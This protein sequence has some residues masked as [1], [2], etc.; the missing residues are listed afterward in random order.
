M[1][2]R[3]RQFE[4]I[5]KRRGGFS[6]V[7]MIAATA[8]VAGTLAPAL[9]VMRDAMAASREASR[10]NLLAI[11]AVQTLEYAAGATMQSWTTGT[12]AGNLAFEGYPTIRYVVTRSDAP[13][14]GGIAGQLMHVQVTV[15][16]DE[17]GNSTWNAGEE[18]VRFRTKVAKLLTYENEAN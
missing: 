2:R 4:A 9:T 7:E 12:D 5:A 6:L 3:R 1:G 10:R 8:L 17:N 11:Y 16:D 15:F 18:A 14:N 13:A